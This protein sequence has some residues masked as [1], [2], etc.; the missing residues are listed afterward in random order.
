MIIK[1]VE[2]GGIIESATFLNNEGSV[3]KKK[4]TGTMIKPVFN[5]NNDT[6][7]EGGVLTL[8]KKIKVFIAG[9]S[10]AATKLPE[11]RPETGWGQMIPEFF[12][13]NVEFLNFAVN[14]R[15]SK[16]FIDEGHLQKILDLIGSGDFLFIQFGHNDAKTEMERHT[17]PFTTYKSYL[18]K[19]IE[20]ARTAGAHPVLLT[21][22][23]RR[24]FDE[25]GKIQDT[26]GN[27]LIAMRELA[28][29]LNVPLIDMSKKSTLFFE[30]LGP[31]KTK[32]IFLWLQPGESVN[33][34]EGI[35]DN[36]H[37]SELGAKEIARL[38]VE[39]II[40]K[41]LKPLCEFVKVKEYNLNS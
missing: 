7:Y 30:K 5:L 9:D 12:P 10:T 32:K 27:Y 39:G 33:Y 31:E 36:T 35:Q 28:S 17:D 15:S 23:H 16:S 4:F 18:T 26:H 37:F 2:N 38:V 41:Q 13:E 8:N 21:P 1:L 40:E 3:E 19:Y 20:G 11:K 14:G 29:E 24:F 25:N 34:P 22:I 6:Y